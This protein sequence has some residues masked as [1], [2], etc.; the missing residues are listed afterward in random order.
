MDLLFLNNLFYFFFFYDIIIFFLGGNE[1][2]LIFRS[3]VDWDPILELELIIRYIA[4]RYWD[5]RPRILS[6]F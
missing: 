5:G 2:L 4:K 6:I 1:N 3:M